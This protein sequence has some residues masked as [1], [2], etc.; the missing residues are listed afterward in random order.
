MGNCSIG[1]KENKVN[2]EKVIIDKEL[3]TKSKKGDP[4]SSHISNDSYSR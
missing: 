2:V 3:N 4:Q 1:K